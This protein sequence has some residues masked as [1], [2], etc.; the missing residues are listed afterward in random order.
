[1]TK[2][3]RD[4]SL[5]RAKDLADHLRQAYTAEERLTGGFYR[6]EVISA[7]MHFVEYMTSLDAGFFDAMRRVVRGESLTLPAAPSSE[8]IAAE[9]RTRRTLAFVNNASWFA[10]GVVVASVLT[11]A[12]VA[13]ARWQR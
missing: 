10:A 9:R 11:A 3:P 2:P 8:L 12:L 7:I 5:D 1:M 13:F 6:L 4:V